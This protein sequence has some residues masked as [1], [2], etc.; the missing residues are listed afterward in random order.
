[1]GV[2]S[3]KLGEGGRAGAFVYNTCWVGL[4]LRGTDGD[5][6]SPTHDPIHNFASMALPMVG[7]FNVYPRFHTTVV[8]WKLG[9][10]QTLARHAERLPLMPASTRRLLNSVYSSVLKKI[11]SHIPNI[12]NISKRPTP[13]YAPSSRPLSE[14]NS[15][16]LVPLS[17]NLAYLPIL[18]IVQPT[19]FARSVCQLM[20]KQQCEI[21]L[22]CQ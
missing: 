15:I 17:L 10:S 9:K 16:S 1:M 7:I 6:A 11:A 2:Y 5:D 22:H 18:F 3:A 13:L 4:S 20:N 19:H 12:L 21:S 8:V 14:L